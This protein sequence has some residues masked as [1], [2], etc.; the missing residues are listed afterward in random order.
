[1]T[2]PMLARTQAVQVG[3]DIAPLTANVRHPA[4]QRIPA[5]LI[6]G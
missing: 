6:R 4:E 1:M 3:R 5:V 2:S